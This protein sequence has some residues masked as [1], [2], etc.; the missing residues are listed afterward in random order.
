[1]S[2]GPSFRTSF[3]DML[4]SALGGVALL[5]FLFAAMRRA[6]E[7]QVGRQ[8]SQDLMVWIAPEVGARVFEHVGG[9]LE[10]PNQT[11]ISRIGQDYDD[12]S[13][14]IDIE[15]QKASGTTYRVRIKSSA[16]EP[17]K[18]WLWLATAPSPGVTAVAV[19]VSWQGRDLASISVTN[20]L[21]PV[22]LVP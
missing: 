5:V 14:P 17:L 12:P 7:E 2:S 3:I 15:W 9:C 13:I 1:M 8:V 20:Q 11:L 22:E 4:L 6:Q 19:N 18:L 21:V 16:S 10:L